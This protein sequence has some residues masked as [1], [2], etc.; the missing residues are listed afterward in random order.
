MRSKD[1]SIRPPSAPWE[2]GAARMKCRAAGKSRRPRSSCRRVPRRHLPRHRAPRR[3]GEH[4]QPCH[5]H[6]GGAEIPG[7]FPALR[8]RRSERAEGGHGPPGVGRLDLRQPQS[9]HRQGNAAAGLGLLFDTLSEDSPD[10]ATASYGLLAEWIEV[11]DDGS[12][13][14]FW[15]RPEARFH[16]GSPV[17]PEDV[18]F[19]LEVL[20]T[21]GHPFYRGYYEDV[22]AA[23]PV[24]GDTPSGRRQGVGS[25]SGRASTRSYRAPRPAPGA[26]EDRLGGEGLRRDHPRSSARE[27]P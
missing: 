3:C 10:E 2:G 18:A 16:D 15:L 6:P 20:K 4:H 25:S 17:T 13:T 19:S 11:A 23:E 26:L 1:G 27:R 8:P 9:V 24:E 21:K 22:R 5:G 12:W 7:R 14:T